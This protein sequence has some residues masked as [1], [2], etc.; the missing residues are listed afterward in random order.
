V[1]ELLKP[2]ALAEMLA[3]DRR[4]DGPLPDGLRAAIAA[5]HGDPRRRRAVA[6][7]RAIDR[8]ARHQLARLAVLR[9]NAADPAVLARLSHRLAHLRRA[10][11][12]LRRSATA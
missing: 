8:L 4:Y 3:W 9:R 10:A 7:S 12:A 5:G 2:L 6:A 1:P 11:V